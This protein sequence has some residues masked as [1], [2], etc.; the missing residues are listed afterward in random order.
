MWRGDLNLIVDT[1]NY[2]PT[3][4]LSDSFQYIGPI[5]REPNIAPPSWLERLDPDRPTIYLT[6]GSTD[7]P[8]FFELA[9][10]FFGNSEYQDVITTGGMKK[11]N[12]LPNNFFA[13][14]FAPGSALVKQNDVVVSQSGNSTIYQALSH[15]APIIGIPTMHD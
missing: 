6:M 1:P 9:I 11:F 3:E 4:N 12:K 13:I 8:H 10:E 5:V 15:G 7:H 2:G 14:E